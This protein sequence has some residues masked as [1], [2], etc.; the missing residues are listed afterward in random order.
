MLQVL[1]DQTPLPTTEAREG[2]FGPRHL[3]F[4]LSGLRDMR[5]VIAATQLDR[6]QAPR[7]LDFGGASGRVIRHFRTWRP[8]AELFISDIKPAHVLLAKQ[9]FASQVTALHNSALP[10]LPFPDGYLDCVIAFSVLTHVDSEDTAWLLELR[11]IVKPG[12]HLY[13]TI[14]DQ[15]TWEILPNTVIAPLC[16]ANSDFRRYHAETPQL[17]GRKVHTYSDAAAYQCNVFLGRDYIDRHWAPLFH[18]YSIAPLAHDHQTGLIF[19]V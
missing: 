3:E 6:L 4:W 12:G 18:G 11:R 13:L 10:T 14:H 9:I 15:A 5:K 16:F 8:S 17:T 7:V 19:T 2:Y 1:G